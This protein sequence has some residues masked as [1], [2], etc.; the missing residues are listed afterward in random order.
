VEGIKDEW[1]DFITTQGTVGASTSTPPTN[2]G[3]TTMTRDE[4]LAIKDTSARQQ[5]IAEHHEL[6]GI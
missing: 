6:F 4:I 5:A 3:G 1:A 2:N